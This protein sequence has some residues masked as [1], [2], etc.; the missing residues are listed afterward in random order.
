MSFSRKRL[1]VGQPTKPR[2]PDI[3]GRL[4][5]RAPGPMAMLGVGALFAAS[6][7]G[8]LTGGSAHAASTTTP[9]FQDGVLTIDGDAF[10]NSLTVGRTAGGV[11]TL[12]GVVVL[13]GQATVD[14]VDIIGMDGGAGNDTLRIDESNGAM[15]PAK[16]VGGLG[17]DELAGGSSADILDGADGADAISGKAGADTID[18]G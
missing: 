13:G 18:G 4:R 15:P 7:G 14:N 2:R 8:V 12:N 6:A 11:I 16:M 1:P 10:S 3:G 17:N 9:T 5:Q